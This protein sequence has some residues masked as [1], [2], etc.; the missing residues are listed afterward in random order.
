MSCPIWNADGSAFAVTEWLH[1][2]EQDHTWIQ[3][4]R[5]PQGSAEPSPLQRVHDADAE[6]HVLLARP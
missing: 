2:D 3:V 4:A 1:T 6:I 5:W